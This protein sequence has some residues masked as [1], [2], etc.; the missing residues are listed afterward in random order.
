MGSFVQER[1]VLRSWRNHNAAISA[2]QN[3]LP[4]PNNFVNTFG[5]L[6]T[7]DVPP[8]KEGKAV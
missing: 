6:R 2:A 1:K 3:E 7:Y 8:S 4:T 5:M